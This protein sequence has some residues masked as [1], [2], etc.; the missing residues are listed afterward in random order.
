MLQWT[1]PSH[2]P[3]PSPAPPQFP[4]TCPSVPPTRGEL[5]GGCSPRL[6]GKSHAAAV[7]TQHF[8]PW[9]QEARTPVARWWR[10]R[11]GA[12]SRRRGH[13]GRCCANDD[14]RPFFVFVDGTRSPTPH[15]PEAIK[16]DFFMLAPRARAGWQRAALVP[17]RRAPAAGCI[18][19]SSS[20]STGSALPRHQAENAV[21]KRPPC[22]LCP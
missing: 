8:L 22:V 20:P 12:A 21:L 6:T 18:Q 15:A 7:L 19:N 9:P 17:S 14:E 13:D 4:G 10:R 16:L 5:R 11:R 1:R 2:P 3:P